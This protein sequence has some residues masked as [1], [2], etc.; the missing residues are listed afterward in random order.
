[1]FLHLAATVFMLSAVRAS[2]QVQDLML[3]ELQH[4]DSNHRI[5]AVL[6]FGVL[7]RFRWQVW[8]RMEDGANVY[9]K[10]RIYYAPSWLLDRVTW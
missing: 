1:M 2:D 10:A 7:W 8:P 5:N 3:R 4:E 9:F 6:R